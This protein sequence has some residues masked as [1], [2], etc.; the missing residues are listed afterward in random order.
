MTI[1]YSR[2]PCDEHIV[3]GLCKLPLIRKDLDADPSVFE[4]SA[5]MVQLST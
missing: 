1:L 2:V 4:G 3:A 5:T